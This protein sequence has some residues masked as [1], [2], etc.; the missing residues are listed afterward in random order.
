MKNLFYLTLIFLYT[1]NQ[2]LHAETTL[3][4]GIYNNAP[5]IF[6]DKE[7][8]PSGFFIELLNQ[9]AKDNHWKLNYIPCEWE[10]CLNKLESGELDIMP[11]VA[12]SKTR[13]KRFDFGYEVVLSSWS[14]IYA[15]KE[16]QIFSMLD[17]HAKRIA[18]LKNSIQQE[19]LKESAISFDIYPFF[20]EVESFEQAVKFLK[21]KQVDAMV[22]N[23]FY[24]SQSQVL[25]HF[26]QTNILF[27]PALLKFAF[28]KTLD[29][30]IKTTVDTTLK[31]Y[32]KDPMSIFYTAKN[33]WI[34]QNTHT[35]LPDWVIWTFAAVLMV[36]CIL[37]GLIAFF[38]HLLSRKITALKE[39]EKAL[40]IQSRSA[41]IGEMI[42]MIAYQWKQPLSILSIIANNLKTDADSQTITT[43]KAIQYYEQL[44]RQTL[45]LSRTLDDFQDF[46]K[47]NTKKQPNTNVNTVI[48][49]TLALIEKTLE[50]HEITIIKGYNF[51]PP[52][53][54][55]ANDLVQVIL[56]L[57]K[58]ANEAFLKSP[59]PNK[60]IQLRTFI[61]DQ[62]VY[63]EIEDNAGGM[64]EEARNN[65]FKPSLTTTSNLDST[66]LEL[67]VSKT[68]IEKHFGGKLSVT[69]KDERTCF[70]IS[71][72]LS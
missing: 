71:F 24:G 45:Y 1:F 30:Q 8:Q 43:Q 35:T 17:L 47:P 70:H 20:I 63:I 60:Q 52:L 25:R 2:P 49:N 69:C 64:T 39:S 34:D 14:S 29:T 12:Y 3:N 54:I 18:V 33:K 41:A 66:G 19:A 13:E 23:N 61:N 31:T 44:T 16:S 59:H 32:K 5:K 15:N 27:N 7:N 51:I 46:F 62:T 11:D 37:L 48:D 36:F 57:I 6:L 9:I 53:T 68:I 65:I 26:Y 67:Y 4:V 38:K 50:N 56:N 21:N 58:N 55:Y 42:S 28:S 72:P 40:L 10:E 22:V